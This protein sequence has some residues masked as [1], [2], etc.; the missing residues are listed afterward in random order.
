MAGEQLRVTEGNARGGSL[1]VESDLLIGRAA[2]EEEGRLGDDP[3]ISR[4]H[5]TV[6]RGA[7]GQLDDRGSRVGER[8]VRERRAHRRPA[9]WASATW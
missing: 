6:S 4:R 3:E 1:E 9:S 8:D 2:T 5:A 7:G